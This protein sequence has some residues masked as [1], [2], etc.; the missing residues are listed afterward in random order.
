MGRDT[1]QGGSARPDDAAIRNELLLLALRRGRD[2]SFCPSEVAR[3]LSRD[4]R[5]LMSD[6][7]RVAAGMEEVEAVQKG[8]PVDPLT[9]RGP[10]RL[11]LR[12]IGG[13]YPCR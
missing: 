10:I 3:A 1:G 2:K 5:G 9:A 13:T 11:R 6:V 7:R 12:S 4:W 8:L